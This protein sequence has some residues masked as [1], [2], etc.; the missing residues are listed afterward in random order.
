MSFSDLEN[1][2]TAVKVVND[3]ED[4]PKDEAD[5]TQKAVKESTE[6]AAAKVEERAESDASWVKRHSGLATA[7]FIFTVVQFVLQCTAAA[8]GTRLDVYLAIGGLIWSGCKLLMWIYTLSLWDPA[9]RNNNDDD[10][11]LCMC[12]FFPWIFIIVSIVVVIVPIVNPQTNFNDYRVRQVARYRQEEGYKSMSGCF[13]LIELM[14]ALITLFA[15]NGGV[16]F[17]F[18]SFMSSLGCEIVERVV[19]HNILY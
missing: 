3:L 14:C 12:I 17:A 6:Q 19:E 15:E 2:C 18:I 13:M 8:G 10:C 4:L 1:A 7:Y 9:G 16:N 5:L 11:N